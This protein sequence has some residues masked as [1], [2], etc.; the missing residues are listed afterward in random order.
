MLKKLQNILSPSH[1]ECFV[2]W[3]LVESADLALA[4]RSRSSWLPRKAIHHATKSATKSARLHLLPEDVLRVIFEAFLIVC[5]TPSPTNLSG[6]GPSKVRINFERMYA[7]FLLSSVCRNWRALALEIPSLW[8]YIGLT[9]IDARSFNYRNIASK[10]QLAAMEA[11]KDHTLAMIT[12][13]LA[14]SKNALLTVVMPMLRLD[15][16]QGNY[17]PS[18]I[19]AAMLMRIGVKL[20]AQH[21]ARWKVWQA[22]TI[23]DLWLLWNFIAPHDSWP[24]PSN[25]TFIVRLPKLVDWTFETYWY[26][27]GVDRADDISHDGHGVVFEA[28]ALQ[29]ARTLHGDG[30]IILEATML[31][32]VLG[33]TWSR[34]RGRALRLVQPVL[35]ELSIQSHTVGQRGAAMALLHA[36]APTLRVL[37][38]SVKLLG[39]PLPGDPEFAVPLQMPHLV[40]L[41][42]VERDDFPPH[43]LNPWLSHLGIGS[44]TRLCTIR[45]SWLPDTLD[46]PR[47]DRQSQNMRLRHFV[48]VLDEMRVECDELD[49][50]GATLGAYASITLADRARVLGLTDCEIDCSF[51]AGL[52]LWKGVTREVQLDNSVLWV[53]EALHLTTLAVTEEGQGYV[54]S[55]LRIP[56]FRDVLS[57]GGVR[58]SV[59]WELVAVPELE[60][61]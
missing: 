53:P 43:L 42:W 10:R 47:P 24:T 55:L 23:G 19:Y 33:T 22:C 6:F 34:R 18:W 39:T 61:S 15:L 12:L 32:P 26:S 14:R 13:L 57:G 56:R 45:F 20:L 16:A 11:V 27:P 44:T 60:V 1:P 29:A 5:T 40:E 3:D 2:D 59:P 28:P 54:S 35:Q 38:L 48:N 58:Q 37:E 51:F 46:A 49:I 4:A 25:R 7:P 8:T 30:M 41:R 17:P 21:Q 31:G 52:H 9:V 36:V 50:R